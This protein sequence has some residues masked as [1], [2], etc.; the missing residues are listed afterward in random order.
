MEEKRISLSWTGGK[1]ILI[2]KLDRDRTQPQA[3][4]LIS[5]LNIDYKF[6][7]TILAVRLKVVI[8]R[9]IHL[10]EIGFL[11]IRKLGDNIRRVIINLTDYVNQ[12]EEPIIYYCIDTEKVFERLEWDFI[13]GLVGKWGL[14][15][16]FISSVLPLLEWA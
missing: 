2:P 9:C 11:K 5:L 10:D 16:L 12:T 7:S 8:P 4:R 14:S 13:K 3:Y 6:L 1:I 15:S